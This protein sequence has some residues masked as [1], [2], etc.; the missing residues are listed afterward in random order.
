MKGS[1]S[2]FNEFIDTWRTDDD[3]FERG[4]EERFVDAVG[5]KPVLTAPLFR[6]GPSEKYKLTAKDFSKVVFYAPDARSYAELAKSLGFDKGQIQD[7]LYAQI[8]TPAQPQLC[9]V[10]CCPGYCGPG[11]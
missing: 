11:R 10:G 9:H 7:P 4:A 6:Q 8:E 1:Y 3:I 5:Y 2:I